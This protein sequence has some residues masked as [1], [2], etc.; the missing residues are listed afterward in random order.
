MQKPVDGLG[1]N[2]ERI[3]EL[4]TDRDTQP[5]QLIYL[6]TRGKHFANPC[7]LGMFYIGAR[8]FDT[9]RAMARTSR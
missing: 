3:M 4:F 8:A 1:A 5:F 7:L 2:P 6:V 9:A